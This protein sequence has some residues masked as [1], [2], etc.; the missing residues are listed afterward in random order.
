MGHFQ[1][2]VGYIDAKKGP[3]LREVS[4][5]LDPLIRNPLTLASPETKA[6]LKA[7]AAIE[8]DITGLQPWDRS[9]WDQALQ[10]ARGRAS[11]IEPSP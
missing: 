2:L 5:V 3:F 9:P 8:L 1:S 10:V 6:A 11:T 7:L 4:A